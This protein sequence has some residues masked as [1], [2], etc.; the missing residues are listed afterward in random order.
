MHN[1]LQSIHCADGYS[2]LQG[3]RQ[4]SRG[5]VGIC[6]QLA[7]P[8]AECE[9]LG[10]Q[11][12]CMNGWYSD[13]INEVDVKD[14]HCTLIFTL[15]NQLVSRYFEPSQPQRITSRLE[16]MFNLSPTFL[17]SMQV[18][19]PQIIQKQQNQSRHKC[20]EN[21]QKHHKQNIF[22][23]LV[24]SA[25]PLLKKALKALHR[26]INTRFFLKYKKKEWTEAIKTF[27]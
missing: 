16:L 27:K 6:S 12:H 21:T 26:F 1:P 8:R 22:K 17:P 20:T 3:A 10:A 15:L 7:S 13:S 25:L 18:I 9:R 24:P 14:F 11:H 23:E 2:Q 5:V 19:K 4:K